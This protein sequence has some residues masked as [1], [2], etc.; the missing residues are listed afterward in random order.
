LT[1]GLLGSVL[2]LLCQLAVAADDRAGRGVSL[3]YVSNMIGSAVVSRLIGFVAMQYFGLRQISLQLG[4]A[5]VIAGAAVLLFDQGRFRMPAGW[6]A[7]AI[8]AALVG[9]APESPLY[10]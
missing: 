4:L 7:A 2:P 6:A 1:A 9:V 3:V 10:S 8:G 5:A